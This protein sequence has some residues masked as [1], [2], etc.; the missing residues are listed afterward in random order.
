MGNYRVRDHEL[1]TIESVL[2][3]PI[4]HS[5]YRL[6]SKEDIQM[7]A[8]DS[9]PLRWFVLLGLVELFQD[10]PHIHWPLVTVTRTGE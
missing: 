4:V 3:T 1:G 5:N 2:N 9:S 7:F 6:N 8:S 10:V